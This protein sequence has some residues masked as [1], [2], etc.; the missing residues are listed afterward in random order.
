MTSLA[1]TNALPNQMTANTSTSSLPL[2]SVVIPALDE[3]NGI[4]E[5]IERVLSI[6]DELNKIGMRGPELIV[7]D[8]GSTDR[9]A[10]IV[11]SYDGAD[12][13]SHDVNRGYG[14]AIKTGLAQ[15]KG[16]YVS[17]LDA[18]GTYPPEHF[19]RLC[20]KA[21]TGYDLVIGTR[22][23]GSETGM[24]LV[25]KI[26]NFIF[27]NMLTILG[28]RRVTDSASGQR[29]IN[30]D[31]LQKLYPLPDGLNFTPIMSVRAMHENIKMVEIPI[32]Y[33]ERVGDSKLSVVKDG[34]RYVQTITWTTLGY[35][36]VRVFGILGLAGIAIAAI[37]GLSVLIARVGGTTSL[38]GWG[39]AAIFAALVTSVA[40]VS[41][42]NLGATFNYLVSLVGN[43]P[44]QAGMF[45]KPMFD[46][47]LDRKF[48]Y[49]GLALTI[50]GIIA[51]VISMVLGINGWDVSRLWLYLV[52]SAMVILVG[53]QLM[54]SWIVMRILE[55][56]SLRD[57]HAEQDIKGIR[58]R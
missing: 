13:I 17:F 12:L 44:G 32:P 30:R 42:F 38:G 22:M 26:G 43:L 14:A 33:S 16:D 10:E 1:A 6:S 5:I 54:A 24:P 2:F 47:P 53:I 56:L 23:A 20:A 15:A 8:D 35:N 29:V 3:E 9:T 34:L 4:A 7:V 45:G 46:P 52:S 27:A 58:N 41:L 11:N 48:G 49:I 25:R 50:V 31:I 39:V 21:L 18:D 55:E 57:M 28:T 19:P 40:G 51:A 37:I 36:P